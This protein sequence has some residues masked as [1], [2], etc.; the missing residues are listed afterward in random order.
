M[1]EHGK[2]EAEKKAEARVRES[3]EK[4]SGSCLVPCNKCSVI[5]IKNSRRFSNTQIHKWKF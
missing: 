5:Q 1:C 2:K 4:I 3:G